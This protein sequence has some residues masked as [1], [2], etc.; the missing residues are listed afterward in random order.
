MSGTVI[1]G[2]DAFYQENPTNKKIIQIRDIRPGYL[3]YIG[4]QLEI[5]QEVIDSPLGTAQARISS[6]RK[7]SVSA[8]NE[9]EP[10][11]RI[12][13]PT[14]AAVRAPCRII[15]WKNGLQEDPG[16]DTKTVYISTHN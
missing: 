1:N 13:I 2:R 3:K 14:T 8:V 5:F 15:Y 9:S 11:P 7:I 4:L 12:F 6:D 16:S 10:R